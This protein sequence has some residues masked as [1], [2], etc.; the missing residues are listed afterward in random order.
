[1]MAPCSCSGVE[2]HDKDITRTSNRP[3]TKSLFIQMPTH[4]PPRGLLSNV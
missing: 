1:M 4:R 2:P 3:H